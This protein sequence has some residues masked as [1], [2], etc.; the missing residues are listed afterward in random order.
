MK[1][2]RKII[3]EIAISKLVPITSDDGGYK[4]RE[5]LICGAMGYERNSDYGYR[6]GTP[7]DDDYTSSGYHMS[8]DITHK[9]TCLLNQYIDRKTGKLIPKS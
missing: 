8:N 5:C 6:H 7:M 4:G 9:R 1:K 3:V 2:D